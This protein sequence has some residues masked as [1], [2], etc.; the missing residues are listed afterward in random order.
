MAYLEILNDLKESWNNDFYL[1]SYQ[2][3]YFCMFDNGFEGICGFYAYDSILILYEAITNAL[4]Y[5][6][7]C[8]IFPLNSF[9]LWQYV[10][11]SCSN[12]HYWASQLWNYVFDVFGDQYGK[13]LLLRF[14]ALDYNVMCP[15]QQIHTKLFLDEIHLLKFWLNVIYV[16]VEIYTWFIYKAFILSSKR[17]KR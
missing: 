16:L 7:Y 4:K 10:K 14:W 2:L 3:L 6:F 8:F 11:G 15:V 13:N 1:W 12:K 5:F 9:F 17:R